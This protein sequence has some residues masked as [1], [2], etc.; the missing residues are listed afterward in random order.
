MRRYLVVA[1][2]TLTSDD[3]VE[4]I[5]ERAKAEPSEFYIVVPATPIMEMRLEVAAMPYVGGLPLIPAS[6][7]QARALAEERLTEALTQLKDVGGKVEGQVGDLDPVRAVQAALK[8]QQ[9]DE[10]IV[11]TLPKTISRWLR[12]D[13]PCRLEKCGLPVTHVEAAA[14]QKS[15]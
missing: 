3:L 6:P 13:L 11:S 15:R 10:I 14:K 4:L 5:N 2:Q 7:E 8:A 9:F 12:Q 1:N